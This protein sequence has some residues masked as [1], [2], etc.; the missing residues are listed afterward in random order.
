MNHNYRN[1]AT[2]STHNKCHVQFLSIDY[3]QVFFVIHVCQLYVLY[4]LGAISDVQLR[5]IVI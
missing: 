1:L 4:L 3:S 5:Q 2:A